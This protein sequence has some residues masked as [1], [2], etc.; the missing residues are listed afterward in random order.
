MFCG[1]SLF[2]FISGGLLIKKYSPLLP[3]Y[4]IEFRTKSKNDTAFNGLHL[5]Q[6][7]HRSEI[8]MLR[9]CS[10]RLSIR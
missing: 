4:F 3:L 2:L 10:G 8:C 9:P 1:S 7:K 5:D 6:K